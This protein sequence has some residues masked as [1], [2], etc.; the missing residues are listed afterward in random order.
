MSE[1]SPRTITQL[2]AIA[3]KLRDDPEYMA[4]ILAAYQK[5]ENLTDTQLR[6]KLGTNEHMFARLALCKRPL[7]NSPDFQVQINQI[8]EY[9]N[10]DNLTLVN[11]IRHVDAL[12]ALSNQWVGEDRKADSAQDLPAQPGLM[13]ATRD[14]SDPETSQSEKSEDNSEEGN[15]E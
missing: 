14:K 8:A 1:L 5:F 12:T 15:D 7:P 3:R 11:M 2:Q 4:W 13:A 9:S 10:I 6:N